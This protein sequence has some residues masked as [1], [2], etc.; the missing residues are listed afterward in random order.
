MAT[1]DSTTTFVYFI[2]AGSS[3]I[4]IGVATDPSARMR[5]LQ[6]AHYQQ[7]HLLYTIACASRE[8]A[9]ELEKAFHRWYDD[10][11]IRNE[12]FNLTPQKIGDDINLLMSLSQGV[13]YERH[14]SE[15]ALAKMEMR[16]QRRAVARAANVRQAILDHLSMNPDDASL[17]SRQ[18]AQAIGVGHD[19]ANRYRNEWLSTYQ[20][21]E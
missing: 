7:L 2:S 8:H 3:P 19:S 12:W 20:E 6:T 5:D 17:S 13:T 4:K 15:S 21:G 10:V 9:F 14:T 11:Q 16:A 18:L 1:S